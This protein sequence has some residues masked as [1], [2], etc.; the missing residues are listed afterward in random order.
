[1]KIRP[2]NKKQKIYLARHNLNK[3]FNKQAK[4]FQENPSY[5]SLHTE[6]LEPESERIYSF[7]VDRKYRVLFIFIK[8]D[9]IEIVDI[10]DHYQ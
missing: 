4:I 2:L 6:L 1:M 7:R 8:V 3:K 5:P 10:S 9:E